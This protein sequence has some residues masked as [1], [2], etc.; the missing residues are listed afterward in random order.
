MIEREFIELLKQMPLHPG[1]RNL[2]D[3]AAIIPF[4]D[5]NL[6]F[7]KDIMVQG[8]HYFTDAD[9][10]DVAWKLLTVNL[11]DLA[12]K[13]ALPIGVMLGFTLSKDDDWDKS[14]LEG[15]QTALRHYDVKLLGG[16]TVT[17][18][19]R[20]LSLTAIGVSGH[21]V[22][23]RSGAQDGD[24]LYVSGPI[25]DAYAGYE[26][27]KSGTY[28]KTDSLALAFNRPEPQLELGQNIARSV[29][30]MMDI[31]DGILI[32]VQRMAAASG[33]AVSIALDSLPISQNYHQKFGNDLDSILK[34]ATWGDDYQLLCAAPV[35]VKLP[36]NMIAVG[37]FTLGNGLALSYNGGNVILPPA[38]GYEHVI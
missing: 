22:P 7:T 36:K 12:A 2:N 15:F 19:Q 27:I 6:I 16:D 34:A 28:D 23:S 14:F 20:I 26:M 1:A 10:Q 21:N 17:S 38:L 31:S 33:L 5:K 30:A 32:D 25:G 9:P 4:S 8:V 29:N 3:D 11:S 13:G 24:T 18:Q 35:G 37:K